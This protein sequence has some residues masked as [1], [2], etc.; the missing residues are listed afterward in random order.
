[1]Q[2]SSDHISHTGKKI[3]EIKQDLGQT[4][5]VREL[6]TST[7]YIKI[8]QKKKLGIPIGQRWDKK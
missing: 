1:M 8:D 5:T 4:K 2:R 7:A 6:P 3:K